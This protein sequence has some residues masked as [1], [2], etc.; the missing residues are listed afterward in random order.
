[1]EAIRQD[2]ED[3]MQLNLQI[4][5]AI[6]ASTIQDAEVQPRRSGALDHAWHHG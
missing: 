6:A 1:M 2:M 5:D 4:K 3:E